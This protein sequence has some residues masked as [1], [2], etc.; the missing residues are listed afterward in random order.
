[1]KLIVTIDTE[2]DN[3]GDFRRDGWTLQNIDCV[4]ALQG[5]FESYGVI[6][7]YMVTYAAATGDRSRS[8]L[9]EISQSGKCEIGAHCHPWHTPPLEEV[10]GARN[11]MLCNLPPELQHEKVRRLDDAIREHV[12]VRPSSFRSGRWG[13]GTEVARCLHQLGYTVDSSIASYTDWSLSHG[14]DFSRLSPSPFRFSPERIFTP[15]P[16]GPML[17]VPATIGYAQE[18]FSRANATYQWVRRWSGSARIWVSLLD[19]LRVVNRIWLSPETSTAEEMI[20]LARVMMRTGHPV[21]NM[22]FHSPALAVGLTP[23][24]RTPA[25]QRALIRRIETFLQFTR[26]ANIESISLSNASRCL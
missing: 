2:E 7:T 12:G 25:E 13:Y 20:Q 15:V 11:S 23:F 19:H 26:S 16:D 18:D 5:L 4:P 21:L 17:E 9:R 3:W 8:I 22:V 14:P 6:P 24:V 10:I 1:M